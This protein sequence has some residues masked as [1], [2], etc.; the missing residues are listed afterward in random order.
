MLVKL[1]E[2]IAECFARAAEFRA[3]AKQAADSTQRDFLLDMERRWL[4]LARSY[5]F[6]RRLADFTA[7]V[8]RHIKVD[9]LPHSAVPQVNCPE[10]GKPMRLT[11]IEPT[12]APPRADIAR[13]DCACG[14]SYT[15]TIE[16]RD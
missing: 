7:E 11:S 1:S 8:Q 14:F 4:A 3:R 2:Q 5:E 10:C 13:F 12:M 9:N 15:H 16:R 6:E